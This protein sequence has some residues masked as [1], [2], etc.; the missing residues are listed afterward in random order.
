M[1]ALI[2][3]VLLDSP[4]PQLDHLFDYAIPERLR[5]D[6]NPGARVRVPLRMGNRLVDAYVVGLANSSEFAG[7]LQDIDSVVSPVPL[8]SSQLYSLARR[9]A[10]RQ[11][12]S[13]SDV[14]RLAIP[15]R[16]VRVEKAFQ[17][18]EA[19]GS[20]AESRIRIAAFIK[21][22]PDQ[23]D[24]SHPFFGLTAGDCRSIVMPTGVRTVEQGDVPSWSLPIAQ[25]CVEA[26]RRNE[27]SV[28]VVP[29][30]R[31][32]DELLRVFASFGVRDAV[33][34]TDARQTGGERYAAFLRILEPEPL[35]VIGNRSAI[36]APAHN[37]GLISVWDDGDSLLAEPLA[38][39][40]HARDVALISG[41]INRAIV[42]F[43]SHAPTTDVQ[44][45]VSIGF[46]SEWTA[47]RKSYPTVVPTDSMA[48]G[49]TRARIPSVAWAHAR[50]QCA[51][52]PVLIQVARSGYA[53]ALCCKKC[54]VR[55]TCGTCSGPLAMATARSTPAC[56][57]CGHLSTQWRCEE[58]SGHELRMI[59]AGTIRTAEELGRA[60]PNT[61]VIV[62]DGAN[63][64]QYVDDEPCLVISTPGA[65]PLARGGFRSVIVLDGETYRSRPGLRVDEVAIRHWCNALALARADATCY[66]VG[67]GS[68]LGASIASW[69]LRSFAQSELETRSSLGLPPAR[70][71]ATVT[72]PASDVES[73]C[74]AITSIGRTRVMGPTGNDGG[75]RAIVLFDY[76]DGD[77]VSTAL[78]ASIVTTSTKGARRKAGVASTER[79]MRLRVR[80]DDAELGDAI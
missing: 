40:A 73:A 42:V 4:L 15:P 8:L 60:F 35:I 67:A 22:L 38:P 24:A 28:V 66:L 62:S 18:E 25:A 13:A 79:V 23:I 32:I 68:Q 6:A 53:P 47:P 71:A 58:C 33:V 48:T 37:L 78:R 1:T 56:L 64:V 52:G 20:R 34:R 50:E 9:I 39:Y 7:S 51:R 21:A 29:S 45:L 43:A 41:N 14:L 55:A 16:Y 3:K 30:Y 54:R 27:S 19:R 5:A 69:N 12:G 75:A 17:S 70:R 72:G 10:D 36:Y 77:A 2:A 59:S 74:A 31:D 11:A 44:R 57:W 46:A 26:L 65:E 61:R 49:E 76:R 80:M 63:P